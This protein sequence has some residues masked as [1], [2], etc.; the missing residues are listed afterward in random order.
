MPA[1]P[2]SSWERGQNENGNR[3]IRRFVPKGEMIRECTKKKVQEVE[4]RINSIYRK[5]L[6]WKTADMCFQE[7]LEQILSAAG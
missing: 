5:S 3:I 1:H 4:T 7:E 6:G 2:Y